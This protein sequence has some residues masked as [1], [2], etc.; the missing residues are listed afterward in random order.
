MG[1]RSVFFYQWLKVVSMN[2]DRTSSQHSH[3]NDDADLD[4]DQIWMREAYRQ[5]KF[6]YEADEV[7][8][9]AVV[10]WQGRVIA[11]AHNQVETLKDPTAHAEM[12]AITQAANTL[13]SKW[14]YECT[15]YVTLEPCAMC[16]GALVLSRLKR[17][18]IATAD[19]KTGACGSIFQISHHPQLNHRIDVVYGSLAQ[20]CSEL[21]RRFFRQK[22]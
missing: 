22:R 15:M 1:H 8:I 18:V 11:K 9:G 2:P 12:I 21:L 13:K 5:A 16:A 10:T 7:P 20:P 4:L 3:F 14:L 6:A 17:L 19:P